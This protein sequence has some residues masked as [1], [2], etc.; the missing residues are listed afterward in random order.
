[1]AQPVKVKVLSSARKRS[2][3]VDATIFL[4]GENQLRVVNQRGGPAD[5]IVLAP[6]RAVTTKRKGSTHYVII[7]SGSK[8]VK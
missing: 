1:M 7:E 8:A 2:V 3:Y 5:L 4:E 6:D